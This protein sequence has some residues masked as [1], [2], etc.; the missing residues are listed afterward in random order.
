[1]TEATEGQRGVEWPAGEDLR[2][3]DVSRAYA[4]VVA[5]RSVTFRLGR[6]EVV[7]LIGPNG[8]GKTTLVNILSGYDLPDGGS[9]SMDGEEITAWSPLRRGRARMARTFQHG[10]VFPG[11]SV[12]ENVEVGAL[13]MGARAGAASIV[14]DEILELLGL[15]DV[16]SKSASVLS[17]GQERK[18]GV[19]RALAIDPRYVLMD[20]PAAGLNEEEVLDFAEVVRSVRETQGAGVL[21][22][23]H[24]VALIMKVCDRVY[25]LDQ[26]QV[27][28][29]GTPTDI[30]RDPAVATAYLG[31]IHAG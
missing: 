11:L 9:I 2:A 28:A 25:V 22:I 12:R 7:G 16:A 13:G 8:A 30:M 19:A 20:E 29:E 4:G 5:L 14:A 15:A 24:N 21:V 26:G 6:H 10:H 1:M 18:L 27:I 31:T 17:H 23:D 3:T